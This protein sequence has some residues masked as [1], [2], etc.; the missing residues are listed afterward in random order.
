LTGWGIKSVLTTS[1]ESY[2]PLTWLSLMA[3]S[4]FFGTGAA[5]FHRTNLVLQLLNTLLLFAFLHRAT[6]SPW[7]SFFAASL[8]ALHPM[9]VESVAW[10]TERKDVLSGFF[11]LAG[12]LA[13][14]EYAK[15]DKGIFYF[16][17][18]FSMLMG[19]LSKPIL[20]VFPVVLLIVDLWP[21][22]RFSGRREEQKKIILEKL[23]FFALSAF[24][25]WLTIANQRYLLVPLEHITV[26]QRIYDVA[27]AYFYY[28]S[29][30]LWPGKRLILDRTSAIHLSGFG[31]LL[32]WILVATITIEAW[33]KKER[34]PAV[35]AAWLWY[36]ATLFPVSG[37]VAVGINS[38]ADRFSYLPHIGL[39]ILA[40]W[41]MDAVLGKREDL[42]KTGILFFAVSAIL[43]T[44]FSRA[45]L[46]TWKDSITLFTSQ[47]E[48][49][50][51]AFSER[52]LA[53]SYFAAK[54]FE[55]AETHF[56]KSLEFLPDEALTLNSLGSLQIET[57][58]YLEAETTLEKSLALAPWKYETNFLLALAAAAL[59]EED[60]ALDHYLRAI[61]INPDN[62]ASLYNAGLIYSGRG[63]YSEALPLFQKVTELRPG[64][65]EAFKELGIALVKTGREDEAVAS[66]ERAVEIEPA[67]PVYTFNLAL[68]LSHRGDTRRSAKL[69][70]KILEIDPSHA[71]AHYN[72]GLLLEKNGDMQGA[73]KHY[74]EILKILPD[75]EEVKTALQRSGGKL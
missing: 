26:L 71:G 48:N 4:E 6:G 63:N 62:W 25:S 32:A 10:I 31:A 36:L 3:D 64:N 37:I 67:N 74:R 38:L 33:K 8:W 53:E 30:A 42:K 52:M 40:V 24:F 54:R 11:F 47:V 17:A 12:L 59:G 13:Y 1:L 19:I 57:G 9:R 35:N 16:A 56:R 51:S 39:A 43:L 34:L 46:M 22:E 7:K 75:N 44:A 66:F 2:F 23:P 60:K 58:R 73:Q 49:G 5:G 72:Y 21:L 61:K 70:E 55:D 27:T 41:G 29:E 45:Y 69:F 20:V 14:C 28:L 68:A 50:Q 15:R 65:A 18:L